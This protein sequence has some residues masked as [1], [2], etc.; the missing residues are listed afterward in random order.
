VSGSLQRSRSN[1]NRSGISGLGGVS[2]PSRPGMSMTAGF[3]KHE[4][5]VMQEIEARDFQH[6][7]E[8]KRSR[9][10]Q[11]RHEHTNKLNEQRV[12]VLQE[13]DECNLLQKRWRDEIEADAAR[14]QQEEQGKKAS[15]LEYRR[16][17][18]QERKEQLEE[19]K[20][21]LEQKMQAEKSLGLEMLRMANEASRK[22]E[23]QEERRK[24][25]EREQA[26]KMVEQATT[27]RVIKQQLKEQEHKRDVEMAKQQ[28]EMLDKQDKD[29]GLYFQ[30]I[31]EKQS[32]LLAA[33]EKG[34]G[35]ELEKKAQED[36]ERAKRH[37]RIVLEKEQK[38]AD[39]K[40]RKL[41]EMKRASQEAVQLQ[42]QEHEDKRKAKQD[43]ELA[44][45]ARLRRDGE[46]AD[47]KE[48]EKLDRR[49]GAL[50]ANAAFL[51]TQIRE[52]NEVPTARMDRDRMTL[53]EKLMN[54]AKLEKAKQDDFVKRIPLTAR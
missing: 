23:A 2:Q 15:M 46:E 38:E 12:R 36:E 18:D 33:Y 26:M 6:R 52:R 42:L 24:R 44:F 34:V 13:K 51:R 29:R 43:E 20:G 50:E 19:R 37:Q 7:E 22:A 9:Q 14:Y 10:L 39:S 47:A 8:E 1:E 45:V 41:R 40:E 11:M 17:F 53:V 16:R 27:A 30:N 49:R 25:L 31:K 28:Q 21:Q 4:W 35:N 32:N 5:A 54:K 3:E 48:K